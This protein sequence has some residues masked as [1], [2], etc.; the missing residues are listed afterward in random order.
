MLAELVDAGEQLRDAA[1]IR[2]GVEL[3]DEQLRLHESYLADE[4]ERR[5]I[6]AGARAWFTAQRDD[7]RICG[8]WAHS[9]HEAVLE[10]ARFGRLSWCVVDDELEHWHAYAGRAW[11]TSS[12][13][14]SR[15]ELVMLETPAGALF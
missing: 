9:W 11:P 6:E 1:G 4:L 15:A 8:R 2:A 12:R 13:P 7:G 3:T 5:G 14:L 10:L